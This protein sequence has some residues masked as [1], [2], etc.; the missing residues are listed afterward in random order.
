MTRS[1]KL[2]PTRRGLPDYKKLET[3][4]QT[5][6]PCSDWGQFRASEWRPTPAAKLSLQIA[7]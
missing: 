4:Y 3:R 1:E 2:A 6:A 7:D 5:P